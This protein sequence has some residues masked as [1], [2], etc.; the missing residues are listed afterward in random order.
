MTNSNKPHPTVY[1]TDI[2]NNI[3]YLFY[4]PFQTASKITNV[5]VKD[6]NGDGLMDVQ[7]NSTIEGYTFVWTFFQMENGPFYDSGIFERENEKTAAD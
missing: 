7:L 6:L 4:A 1:L 2:S 3:L 5:T